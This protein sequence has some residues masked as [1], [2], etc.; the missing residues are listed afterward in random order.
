MDQGINPK[1]KQSKE[2]TRHGCFLQNVPK[3]YRLVASA[4]SGAAEGTKP[5]VN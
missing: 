4:K 5:G 3:K 2:W 1:A